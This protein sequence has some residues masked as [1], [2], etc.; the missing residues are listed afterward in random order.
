[1]EALIAR[2]YEYRRLLGRRALVGGSL[3]AESQ[4]RLA[5]LES[6]LK[7]DAGPSNRTFTRTQVEISATLIQ[8]RRS[9]PVSVV[10]ISGG[11]IRITPAPTLRP[12][13]KATVRIASSEAGQIY[14][15][16][17]EV[18]WCFRDAE[19]S[20]MGLPFTGTPRHGP[21]HA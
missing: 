4:N 21:L 7:G 17:V 14:H 16:P 10:D 15:Y 13:D 9:S 19:G 18:R 11:G 8:G 2:I 5:A 6:E 3:S 1:M 20:A 12:G